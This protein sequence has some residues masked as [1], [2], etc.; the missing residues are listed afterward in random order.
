MENSYGL[1]KPEQWQHESFLALLFHYDHVEA[2][3]M[4]DASKERPKNHNWNRAKELLEILI[5]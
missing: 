3:F 1:K 2:C 4:A 5:E